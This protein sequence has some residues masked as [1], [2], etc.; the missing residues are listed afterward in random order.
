MTT[1]CSFKPLTFDV[2]CYA[3]IDNQ[4]MDGLFETLRCLEDS[5]VDVFQSSLDRF[6]VVDVWSS[7]SEIKA[8][9]IDLGTRR[10]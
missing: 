2:A 8:A 5:Q 1:K 3:V 9:L 7:R 4:S 6:H 10:M